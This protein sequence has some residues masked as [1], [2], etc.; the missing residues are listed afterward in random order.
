MRSY[1]PEVRKL[2]LDGIARIAEGEAI[3]AGM[4]ED[5]MPVVTVRDDEYTP[6][7]YNTEPLSTAR[8]RVFTARFGADR[9]VEP[10]PV[11]G[12]EDF[13]RFYRADKTIESLIFWVGGAPIDKWQ[14]AKGDAA[15]LPSLHCPFWAPD[16]EAVIS[17]ATEA[18]T[19]LAL[20]ILKRPE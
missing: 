14:A 5:T 7:T 11:M 20:D 2:L 19:T 18:M 6:S 8:S 13:G 12:G 16:A 15:K 4:P 3:A 1:T 10:P 17:T 9:V